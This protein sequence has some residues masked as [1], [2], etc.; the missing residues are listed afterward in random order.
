M[1]RGELEWW[2]DYGSALLWHGSSA[3]SLITLPLEDRLRERLETWVGQY[4]DER[5]P[6]DGVGDADWVREGQHLLAEV[7]EALNE[8]HTVTVVEPWW[9][10]GAGA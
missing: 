6:F 7:R 2:P 10:P 9:E 8:T 5:L 4:D 1:A 3:V